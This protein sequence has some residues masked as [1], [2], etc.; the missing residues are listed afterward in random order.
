MKKIIISLILVIIL[1]IVSWGYVSGLKSWVNDEILTHTDLNSNF[2]DLNSGIDDAIADIAD[3]LFLRLLKTSF[4]DSINAR[5]VDSYPLFWVNSFADSTAENDSLTIEITKKSLIGTK[6]ALYVD[7]QAGESETVTIVLDGYLTSKMATL[8][9]INFN[10]W[11]ETTDDTDYVT[12]NVYQDSTTAYFK[13]T[14]A[15]TGATLHSSTARTTVLKS[16]TDIDITG[17]TFRIEFII[18]S[19]SDTLYIG[20]VEV[21]VTN[22]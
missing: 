15:A 17:D 4:N 14:A 8:D 16:V 9:S 18:V 19:E 7:N 13:G 6:Q 1:P 10:L 5:F 12:V 20:E 3:S 2:T 11:T 21:F 22:P